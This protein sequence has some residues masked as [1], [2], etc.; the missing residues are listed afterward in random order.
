MY[1]TQTCHYDEATAYRTGIEVCESEDVRQK[2]AEKG[3]LEEYRRQ[4]S[5]WRRFMRDP[6]NCTG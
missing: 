4:M 3:E 1:T 2:C 6:P 5:A